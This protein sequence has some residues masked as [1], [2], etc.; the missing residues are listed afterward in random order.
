MMSYKTDFPIFQHPENRSLVYLDNAASTQ[1]PRRVIDAMS[2]FYEKNNANIHRGVYQLSERATADYESV[3]K[4][5][6]QFIHARDI[7][8]IIFTRSTTES[9]NLVAHGLGNSDIQTGDEILISEM[10]H[11]SNIVPWQMLCEKT[12][13]ILRVIP[14]L[15]SGVLDLPTYR[16]MLNVKTKFVAIAHVSN[17]LGTINPI[18]SMIAAAHQVGAKVLVDGA[19]AVAHIPINMI[20]L[21]CDFYA[22]SSHKLYGPTGVG[23]L[24]GKKQLLERLPVYQTGGDMIAQV[25]FK[26][27]TFNALP[28]KFEAG[29]PNIAG[30]VGLGAAV[31]YVARIGFGTI[32]AHEN[33]L[34]RVATE[35][36]SAFEGL[37]IVGNTSD[38][39]GVIAFTIEGVHPH[40]V[41]T[42]LDQSGVAI[43]AGHHCAMPL[44]DRFGISALSRVSFGLYNELRD[45][46]VL[47]QGLK[48][49]KKIF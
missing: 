24:Y 26:K 36:F 27:T 1:K 10:E 48:E 39:I 33:Q 43:R 49:V 15:D 42:I 35:R 5:I 11:H 44:I 23:V 40:D 17:V 2:D 14:V 4:K 46:D 7:C 45:I 25:T 32:Q 16:A 9:I 29:T 20:D 3:R 28:Y 22:F 12:G 38:K 37:T 6:Q 21:D 41:A 13:A 31:D 19:Q 8:E 18:K 47:M 34:L 30:V